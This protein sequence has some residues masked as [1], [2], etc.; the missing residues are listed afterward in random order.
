[1]LSCYSRNKRK[2]IYPELDNPISEEEIQKVI[3]N[4][5]SK[6]SPV[7]IIYLMNILLRFRIF[8]TYVVTFV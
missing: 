8:L 5:K 6:K 2:C 7:L 1:M 3:S 4:L